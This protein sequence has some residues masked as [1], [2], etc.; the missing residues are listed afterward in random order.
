ML[1]IEEHWE[2]KDHS[3]HNW[4]GLPGSAFILKIQQHGVIKM[5]ARS[6]LLFINAREHPSQTFWPAVKQQDRESG[7]NM[8]QRLNMKWNIQQRGK[9]YSENAF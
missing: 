7:R 2:W 8:A 6:P 3:V 4:E 9:F 1:R 5:F